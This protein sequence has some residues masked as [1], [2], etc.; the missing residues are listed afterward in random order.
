M[1]RRE[2]ATPKREPVTRKPRR[3]GLLTAEKPDDAEMAGRYARCLNLIR[4]GAPHS[5][6]IESL[7]SEFGI[8]RVQATYAYEQVTKRL[9]AEFEAGIPTAKAKQLER[10]EVHL[11]TL[12]AKSR[13]VK[14]VG[15]GKDVREVAAD[16]VRFAPAIARLEDLIAKISGTHAPLRVKVDTDTAMTDGLVAIVAGLTAEDRQKLLDEQR[17]LER[18]AADAGR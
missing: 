16:P 14:T 3:D 6:T 5:L 2:R 10:L 1:A 18:R 9:Q 17:E 11:A 7:Q 4:G 12:Y 13:E 8:T 15:T